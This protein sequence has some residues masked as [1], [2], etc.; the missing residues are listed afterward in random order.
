MTI[1]PAYTLRNYE[2][3][4]MRRRTLA[5]IERHEAN[6]SVERIRTV[7]TPWVIDAQGNPTRWVYAEEDKANG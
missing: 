3:E 2:R 6:F 1:S 4:R 5:A 7:I